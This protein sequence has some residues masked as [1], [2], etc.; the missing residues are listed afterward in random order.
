MITAILNRTNEPL[1]FYSYTYLSV[2]VGAIYLKAP[3]I[4]RKLLYGRNLSIREHS[5]LIRNKS[6]PTKQPHYLQRESG[7]IR[8]QVSAR[9][10]FDRTI[11]S[12]SGLLS[13]SLV[14]VTS[15]FSKITVMEAGTRKLSSVRI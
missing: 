3:Q 9:C 2:A 4:S 8:F 11:W 5:C 10:R 13:A 7:L 12:T 14:P 1:I 6:K 15:T